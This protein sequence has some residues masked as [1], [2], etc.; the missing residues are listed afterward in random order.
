MIHGN[1]ESHS[2]PIRQ[3]S[4]P[5]LWVS[6]VINLDVDTQILPVTGE[7]NSCCGWTES[8][9]HV[10]TWHPP[11][12][13]D[14]C[15]ARAHAQYMEWNLHIWRWAFFSPPVASPFC[16]LG[17]CD[18]MWPYYKFNKDATVWVCVSAWSLRHWEHLSI[19]ITL[20]TLILNCVC[21][22]VSVCVSDWCVLHVYVLIL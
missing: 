14:R 20:L 21:V 15:L 2:S 18:Q 8:G 12:K 5:N 17:V 11:I 13:R 1:L 19:W 3:S 16:S 4:F 22:C 7:D 6:P 9:P 10:R